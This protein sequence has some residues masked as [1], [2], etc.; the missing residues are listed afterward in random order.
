VVLCAWSVVGQ[1]LPAMLP[2]LPTSLCTHCWAP[3]KGEECRSEGDGALEQVAWR[4]CGVSFS[5]DI[6]DPPGCG[7]G[8]LLYVTLL[9]QAFG[10]GDPQRCLPTP[11]ML[12]FCETWPHRALLRRLPAG[13]TLGG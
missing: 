4:G 13:P 2:T 10:L 11:A 8:S 9:Q 3:K 7:P 1:Q 6:P 12:G 5:G